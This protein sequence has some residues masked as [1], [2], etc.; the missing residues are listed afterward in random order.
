MKRTHLPV[1]MAL[2]AMLTMGLAGCAQG[3]QGVGTPAGQG[4]P[5]VTE[6]P[7]T[8]GSAADAAADAGQEEAVT[9]QTE[10]A[11]VYKARMNRACEFVFNWQTTTGYDPD[12]DTILWPIDEWHD[13]ALAYIAP[14]SG[15]YEAFANTEDPNSPGVVRAALAKAPD[16]NITEV[17]DIV[18]RTAFKITRRVRNPRRRCRLDRADLREL[19]HHHLRREQ[20]DREAGQLGLG[21]GLGGTTH[22]SDGLLRFSRW[23]AAVRLL[24][25][26]R[27]P[28]HLFGFCRHWCALVR[29]AT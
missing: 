20:P 1:A 27:P 22:G 2:A 24:G 12:D 25:H 29:I 13:R 23:E 3:V 9:V 8:E 10:S 18:K 16:A 5:S 19:P 7:A 17:A 21:P 15:L 6:A 11:D 14:G 4:T 28:A 26:L